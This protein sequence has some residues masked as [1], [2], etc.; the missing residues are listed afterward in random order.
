MSEVTSKMKTLTVGGVKFSVTDE[1]TQAEMLAAIGMLDDLA[2]TDRSNLVAA[3]NELYKNTGGGGS[4]GSQNNAVMTL[5]NDTGWLYKNIAQNASCKLTMTWSSLEDGVSTGPGALTVKVGGVLRH[6]S[7]VDQG[8]VTVDVGPYLA[9]G[10]NSVRVSVSDIYGN[11]K[12]LAFTINCIVLTL[13]SSFDEAVEY[14]GDIVFPY[15]PTGAVEKKVYFILDGVEIGYYTTSE[16][17]RQQNFTIPAQSHGSHALHVYFTAN[18]DG[19]EITSNGLYYDIICL[20][21]GITT[22]IISSTYRDTDGEQFIPIAISYRVYDPLGLTTAV[23]LLANDV[24]ENSLTVDRT[25][26][27]WSYRPDEYGDL[28]LT[29]KA[30]GAGGEV[31]TKNFTIAVKE[32]DIDVSAT[33]NNL[34]LYLTAYGRSNSESNPSVWSNNGIDAQLTGFNFESDG[35]QMD[36]DNNTVL[37]LAGDARAYIP[38]NIFAQD[39]RSTGKTIEVEF[40]SRDVRNYDAVL[41]SC[42]SG[43]RGLEITT[44]RATMTSE[45][46]AIGTQY[47]EEE[48]VR[49]SF[50]VEKR[51]GNK[52][53]LCYIN[54]IMSGV[55]N[56]PDDDDFSQQTPV[57]ITIGSSEC[58]T[59]IY[60]IRVY[61]S[62]LTRY[63]ILDNWIADT[64]VGIERRERY[65]RNHVY[66]D[67]GAITPDTLKKDLPYLIITAG[68]LPQFK[69]DKKTCSG[70][71][72]DPVNPG[73]SFTFENAEIDVQGTSSQYFG[74]LILAKRYG[75]AKAE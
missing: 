44:Q 60:C 9:A 45:Q 5:K 53:L 52:L 57:G 72:V 62:D 66:D 46:S 70:E 58:T 51:S 54:G 11:S 71:Y 36:D 16:S 42:M 35:W 69:G 73:K 12:T 10:S 59:D 41:F 37:R 55:V 6:S 14:T 26:R 63:Q 3:I 21:N 17:G 56:Y 25:K 8:S 4:G 13:T 65:E 47:K 75:F 48:H 23:S 34:E 31:A 33:S 40:A 38:L 49:L 1:E 20:E 24:E 67:Y 19:E 22:P 68:A 29:I 2:T 32:S 39:F 43:G 30:T 27:T 15:T 64:Q 7:S 61:N 74:P 18:I 50:V 28:T